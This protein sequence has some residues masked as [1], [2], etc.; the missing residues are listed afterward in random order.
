MKRRRVVAL[1]SLLL[2]VVS[3][4]VLALAGRGHHFVL[5]AETAVTP[6]TAPLILKASADDQGVTIDWEAS[7]VGS[8]PVKAYQIYKQNSDGQFSQIGEVGAD[9]GQFLDSSGRAGDIYKLTSIDDQQPAN[10]SPD[11]DQSTAGGTSPPLPEVARPPAEPAPEPTP[12][13]APLPVATPTPS[14]EITVTPPP[15]ALP[16]AQVSADFVPA[17]V[18]ANVNPQEVKVS[19]LKDL[20]KPPTNLPADTAQ[21]LT[22]QQVQQVQK[23]TSLQ[24]VQLETVIVTAKQPLVEPI[25]SQYTNQVQQLY[26]RFDKLSDSQK[27]Q[28]KDDCQLQKTGLETSLLNLPDHYQID[29][30]KALAQCHLINKQP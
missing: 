20:A 12:E 5:G 22:D 13:P 30:Y 24:V 7:G 29:L 8:F 19:N 2:I 15:T 3:V 6:P 9:L 16:A 28:V 27:S 23:S 26:Q 10:T 4:L 17:E 11:S 21:P 14:P 1:L 18:P 25:L